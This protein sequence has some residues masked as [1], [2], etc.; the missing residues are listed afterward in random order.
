MAN[1]FVKI[2]TVTVGSGGTSAIEFTSIPQTYTDLKILYSIRTTDNSVWYSSRITFNGTAFNVNSSQRGLYGTGSAA[3]SENYAN[4]EFIFVNGNNTT[5]SVFGNAE[6]NIPNY[7]SS[8]N[9]SISGD[10]VTENNSTSAITYLVAGLWSNSAAITSITLA[11]AS[12]TFV[13][14]STATLYGIK[15]S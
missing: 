1:T 10:M 7:T 4:S 9:K 8:N 3:G 13:Q 5:A 6:I 11:P 12:G 14:Y 2:S 15:S